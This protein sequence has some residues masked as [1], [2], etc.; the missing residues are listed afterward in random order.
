V[1]FTET[2]SRS[3]GWQIAVFGNAIFR[4]ERNIAVDVLPRLALEE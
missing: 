4:A 1:F 3:C 2:V